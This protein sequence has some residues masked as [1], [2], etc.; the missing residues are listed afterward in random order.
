VSSIGELCEGWF[1]SEEGG[2]VARV[3]ELGLRVAYP[4][5]RH[6]N[7]KCHCHAT[8]NCKTHQTSSNSVRTC[9]ADSWV[10]STTTATADPYQA[11]KRPV[12]FLDGTLLY[13]VNTKQP[14]QWRV[15]GDTAIPPPIMPVQSTVMVDVSSGGAQCLDGHSSHRSMPGVV[16]KINFD[17]SSAIQ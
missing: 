4:L 2:L 17:G 10:T 1:D 13:D 5:N 6:Q 15:K 8:A 7:V 3:W 9:V 12:C 16:T 11:E 14:M